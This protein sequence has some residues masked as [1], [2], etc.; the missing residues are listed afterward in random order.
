MCKYKA[1][2]RMDTY[3]LGLGTR[4]D[5]VLFIQAFTLRF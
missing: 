3:Y 2:T 4:M 5:S 1:C